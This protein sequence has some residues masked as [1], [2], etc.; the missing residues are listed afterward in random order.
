MGLHDRVCDYDYTYILYSC[1]FIV[2]AQFFFLRG[3]QKL[4]LPSI[5]LGGKL[6]KIL[7]YPNAPKLPPLEPSF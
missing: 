7:A 6:P 1:N 2:L 3:L 4:V 5:Y